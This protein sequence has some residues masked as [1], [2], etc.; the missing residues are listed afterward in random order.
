MKI[1][2][3]LTAFG[4]MCLILFASLLYDTYA[5]QNSQGVRNESSGQTGELYS[6]TLL[7]LDRETGLPLQDAE[8]LVYTS[9]GVQIGGLYIT[10]AE[11]KCYAEL[12]VGSYYF[13][14]VTPPEGYTYE[15]AEGVAIRKYPFTVGE[16]QEE[17]VT[18]T[19]YNIRAEGALTIQKIV[20][21]AD[22]SP[23]S[24]EQ[25][26][27]KFGFI[28]TFGDG[29]SYTYTID[30]GE[31]QTLESGGTIELSHGQMAV[32]ETLPE[33]LLYN[34][35]EVPVEGYTM[36][37]NGHRGN[38]TLE[39]CLAVF[40]NIYMN[41][42]KNPGSLTITKQ[43]LGTDSSGE[44]QV[45]S[46]VLTV[47][48][49]AHTF[50]LKNGESK[51]FENLPAGEE[52]TV[53]EEPA[54]GYI[55]MVSTYRGQILE[56]ENITLPFV[57]Q[58][59]EG[60]TEQTGSLTVQKTVTGETVDAEEVFGFEVTF[61]GEGAPESQ[62]FYLKDG[63]S[64]SLSDIPQGVTYHVQETDFGRCEPAMENVSGVIAANAEARVSFVNHS[65][66]EE[67]A[68]GIIRVTKVMEGEYSAS[69]A[70]REFHFVLVLDGVE[71]EFTLQPEESKIFTAPVGASYEIR[72]ADVYDD[73]QGYSQSIENGMGTVGY[74]I[75]EVRAINRFVGNMQTRI[76]GTKTWELGEYTGILP[77]SITIRLKQG[78]QMVAEQEVFPDAEGNWTYYF[79]VP[80]Y[81]HDNAEIVYSIEEEEVEGFEAIYNGYNVVN[82]Y[83][84]PMTSVGTE[85]PIVYKTVEGDNPPKESFAFILRGLD[86]APMP[87]GST[88]G[89]KTLFQNGSGE[90]DFGQIVFEES[91]IYKYTI[92]ELNGENTNWDYDERIYLIIYE[93]SQSDGSLRVE[94]T[95]V[96]GETEVETVQFVNRY[97]SPIEVDMPSLKKVVEGDDAPK[98]PFVFGLKGTAGQPMPEGSKSDSKT[99]VLT[100]SGELELGKVRFDKAGTYVYTVTE[101][102]TDEL[103]WIYDERVYTIT[104]EVVMEDGQ[105][106]AD[107]TI[108]CDGEWTDQ[109]VFVN[110]FDQGETVIEGV[111]IWQHGKNPSKNWPDSAHIYLYADGELADERTV[112]AEDNWTYSFTMPK[113][114]IDGHEIVYTIGEAEI[115]GY[116]V[117]TDHYDLINVYDTETS[118]G[119]ETVES[120]EPSDGT[121]QNQSQVTTGDN[122]KIFLWMI[123]MMVSLIVLLVILILTIKQYHKDQR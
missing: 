102:Q 83:K 70:G 55:S 75:I 76:S 71:Q 97:A 45:F 78:D 77:Q 37:S 96:L 13:Y 46:F 53:T 11:G 64:W 40:R 44:E 34:V 52:Y 109:I 32:F 112:T 1:K 121:D 98:V 88:N 114:A 66:D 42:E 110:T 68:K 50:T 84:T 2:H 79:D 90:I 10:D 115:P 113:Y 58:Y 94:Q 48:G 26:N 20:E 36:S 43:V 31:A 86:G 65:P 74:G 80:K 6:A 4:L 27:E 49:E 5:W 104:Y 15:Q 81:D 67:T 111:K 29:G 21:N 120:E 123:I 92:S 89:S 100:G 95:I 61:E 101:L 51:V 19:A 122:S 59:D 23:L 118:G 63:E 73:G 60:L 57:N 16:S 108:E 3:I 24:E 93:V 7:K 99:L 8:F 35:A 106:R 18:V 17:T 119:G 107:R 28:V 30:G 9:E 33:G 38:I 103:C 47:A 117:V 25:L 116:V 12:P 22:T 54:E 82:Y 91:G 39:G 14:E 41:S 56:D 105:L 85:L 69:D 87:E 72:E 62:M